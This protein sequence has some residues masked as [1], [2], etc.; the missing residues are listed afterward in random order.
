M[1]ELVERSE[2]DA[3]ILNGLA[4]IHLMFGLHQ[5]ALNLLMLSNWIVKSNRDTLLLMARAQFLLQNWREVV[6]LLDE[7]EGFD[8]REPL[9]EHDVIMKGRALIHLGQKEKAHH[10][11]ESLEPV[12]SEEAV[13]SA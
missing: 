13:A 2:V 5:T 8:L 6:R 4:T 7:V 12:A 11:F 9:T 1:S 10:V 3:D